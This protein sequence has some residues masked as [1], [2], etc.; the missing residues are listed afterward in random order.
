MTKILQQRGEQTPAAIVEDQQL[1]RLALIA[2]ANVLQS[3][4]TWYQ[5]ENGESPVSNLSSPRSEEAAAEQS[6]SGISNGMSAEEGNSN[7]DFASMKQRK[8]YLQE[9]VRLFNWK[10]K[11]GL[12]YLL[13]THCIQSRNSK[14]IAAFLY[15]TEGLNKNF[16]GEYLG[17]GEQEN[18]AT[19]HAFV[20]FMNFTGMQFVEALRLA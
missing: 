12:N 1:R 19:M 2:L 13:D 17:E 9:G 11:K 16:I 18:I 6:D 10:W 8:K 5:K 7:V 3:L 4:V 15:E 14:D 20:E